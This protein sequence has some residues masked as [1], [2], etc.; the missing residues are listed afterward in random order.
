M[1]L[2]VRAAFPIRRRHIRACC[3]TCPRILCTGKTLFSSELSGLIQ[4]VI[5]IQQQVLCN[6]YICRK[7]EGQH[8]NLGI[9]KNVTKVSLTMKAGR[10]DRGI[11]VLLISKLNQIEDIPPDSL[12]KLDIAIHFDISYPPVLFPVAEVFLHNRISVAD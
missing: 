8:K 11:I 12:L 7:I 3:R 4:S 6:R 5:P 9:P 10:T 1:N 2:A